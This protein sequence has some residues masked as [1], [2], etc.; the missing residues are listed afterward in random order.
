MNRTYISKFYKLLLPPGCEPGSLGAVSRCLMHYATTPH[1]SPLL[2]R[3]PLWLQINKSGL[4]ITCSL[5]KTISSALK[6]F[7]PSFFCHI[8][9]KLLAYFCWTKVHLVLRLILYIILYMYS[10]VTLLSKELRMRR[11]LVM[12]SGLVKYVTRM[13]TGCLRMTKVLIFVV[14]D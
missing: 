2:F 9:V 7:F 14:W 5:V 3:C 12:W 10:V 11:S 4:G 6:H 1:N 8:L 13:V